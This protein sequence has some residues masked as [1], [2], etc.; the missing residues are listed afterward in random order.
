MHPHLV[1]PR[2][3]LV[4]LIDVQEGYRKALHEWERTVSRISL[5]LRGARMLELPIVYTEHNLATSYRQPTQAL[6]R[7]T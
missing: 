1:D 4:L 7:L 6:N 2:R 5:L 3:A